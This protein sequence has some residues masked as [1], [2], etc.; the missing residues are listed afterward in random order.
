MV[1]TGKTSFQ[2]QPEVHALAEQGVEQ[3]RQAFDA[4][5]AAAQRTAVALRDQSSTAQATARQF[6]QTAMAFAERNVTSSFEFAQKLL[7]AGSPD[8]VVKLHAEYVRAQIAAL[9]D[10]A[11][12]VA[13]QAAKAVAKPGGREH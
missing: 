2:V 3:A 11:R 8:D 10:Q 13:E 12:E 9:T 7:R 4:L 1:E 5:L 6:Q